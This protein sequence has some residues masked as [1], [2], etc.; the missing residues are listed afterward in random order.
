MH[1]L[2]IKWGKVLHWYAS[3]EA[4][5]LPADAGVEVVGA[6]GEAGSV[7]CPGLFTASLHAEDLNE[8]ATLLL[9]LRWQS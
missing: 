5:G 8:T 1:L 7:T 2:I 3:F 6:W 4:Q 9:I